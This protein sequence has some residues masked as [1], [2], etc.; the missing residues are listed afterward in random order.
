MALPT[1]PFR[2]VYYQAVLVDLCK[3][4]PDLFEPAVRGLCPTDTLRRNGVN[5]H[6]TTSL[7]LGGAA[8]VMDAIDQLC[9]WLP[10]MDAALVHRLGDWLSFHVSNLDFTKFKW[11]P[12]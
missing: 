4:L 9:Q 10:S 7:L 8:Q 6:L 1:A 12:L 3:G 2:P 5:A 11:R